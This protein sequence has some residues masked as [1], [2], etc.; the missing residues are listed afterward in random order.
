MRDFLHLF[1]DEVLPYLCI[2]TRYTKALSWHPSISLPLPAESD[3][4]EYPELKDIA[5]P[6]AKKIL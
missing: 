2:S 4:V 6:S 5:S 3:V 1:T